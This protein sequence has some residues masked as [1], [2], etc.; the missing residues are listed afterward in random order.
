M[1]RGRR[2]RLNVLRSD[3]LA[4]GDLYEGDLLYNVLRIDTRFWDE[5]PDLAQLT[6]SIVQAIEPE[7][8]EDVPADLRD[9]IR[10]AEP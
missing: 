1:R 9:E 2:S 8:L 5:H 3:P 10:K 4:A 6:Q 7:R